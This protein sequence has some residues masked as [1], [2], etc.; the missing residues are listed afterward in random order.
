LFEFTI[1]SILETP[2]RSTAT[3]RQRS[4][5]KQG[6]SYAPRG[7]K[8]KA[9]GIDQGKVQD[10]ENLSNIREFIHSFNK[11]KE[12]DFLTQRLKH[13]NTQFSKKEK[14]IESRMQFVIIQQKTP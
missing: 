1:H 3:N 4:I 8:G 12:F 5:K 11:I 7:N 13:E 2:I 6:I 10:N 9:R 14:A